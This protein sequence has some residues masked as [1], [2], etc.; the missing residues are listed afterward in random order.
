MA[1]YNN[2]F[3]NVFSLD[4]DFKQ[5]PVVQYYGVGVSAPSKDKYEDLAEDGYIKN[6]I[7]YRCVNE[8]AQGACSVPFKVMSGDD[9][10]EEHPVL[11][12]LQRP[13]P[14]MSGSEYFNSLYSYLLLCGNSYILRSGPDFGEPQE[15]HLLRPDRIRIKGGA[16]AIPEAYEY[17][18]NGKVVERYMVD[19]ETGIGEV[20]HLKNWHPLDDHYGLSPMAA[21]AVDIDQYNLAGKHNV[22]LLYNGARPSGAVI[23]KPQDDSGM[24]TYLSE[25]QRQQLLTDLKNRFSGT[26]NT[27]RPLL[28]EGDFDW[29][30]MGLSP[31]D[32][33]F[34]NLRHNTAKDIALCFGVPSQLIGVP[35]AQTYA[36]MAEARLAL[37]EETIIPLMRRVES[38]LN[39]WLMPQF[40]S[41]LLLVY[42]YDSIPALTERRKMVYENVINAVREGVITRNEARERLD[43]EPIDGGDDIYINA[44]M[45]PLGMDIPEEDKETPSID[46]EAFTDVYGDM[47]KTDKKITLDELHETAVS[48][49]NGDKKK[50]SS[51]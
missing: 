43:M 35:D 50:P 24:P 15:L 42:D 47:D 37:Y 20:K 44:S 25:S 36:N 40:N 4:D 31:K 30:E 39:E 19:Q 22:N 13:N 51:T 6:A 32:M 14:M 48:I 46:D 16:R 3:K 1:W 45:F 8:I 21:A 12:L 29:K 5:S 11:S 10:I 7:A 23:F 49:L 28:L 9:V 18:I 33:D 2:L 34:L 41:D 26:S 27:G 17:V 38:D